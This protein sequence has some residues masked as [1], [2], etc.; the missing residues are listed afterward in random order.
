MAAKHA[1]HVIIRGLRV[2]NATDD[3]VVV[4]NFQ[5]MKTL[6]RNRIQDVVA[7]G[8]DLSD[9]VIENCDISNWGSLCVPEMSRRWAAWTPA[10]WW[11]PPY[12]GWSC[13]GIESIIL[14]TLP[15]DGASN[16]ASLTRG[17]RGA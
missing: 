11:A 15:R 7:L 5:A 4:G 9:V 10:S 2:V 16:S 12:P 6:S 8:A 3:A 14:A 17:A 13:N 1:R